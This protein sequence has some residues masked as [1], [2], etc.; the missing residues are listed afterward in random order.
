VIGAGVRD[1]ARAVLFVDGSN[2]YKLIGPRSWVGTH[3][4]IGALKQAWSATAYS[5]QRRFLSLIRRDDPRISV[6][7]GRLEKRS[8]QNPLVD[9][10]RLFLTRQQSR[11]APELVSELS[12]LATAHARVSVLKEKAVDVML[13]VDMVELASADRYDAAYLLSA[14]GDFTPAVEAVEKRGKTVYA[15]SPM[16]SSQLQRV[17]KAFI[18]LRPDWFADCYR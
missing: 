4:Y 3:Y 2:W 17:A 18:P 14:D 7:L 6:H 5:N 9:S 1:S 16:F 13:A 12:A 8:R 11:L 10:L 15:A